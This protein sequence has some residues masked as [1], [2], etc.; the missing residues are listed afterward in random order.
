M[1][2]EVQNKTDAIE[3]RFPYFDKAELQTVADPV[4]RYRIAT[5]GVD[6]ALAEKYHLDMNRQPD[7]IASQLMAG[8][9]VRERM[10]AKQIRAAQATELSGI[11]K[12]LLS[13]ILNGA[14]PFSIIPSVL[15]PFCYNV[16]LESCHKVMFGE[17]GRIDLPVPY[18]LT[19]KAMLG[20]DEPAREFL[21]GYAQKKAEAFDR[22][23]RESMNAAET[24]IDTEADAGKNE[25]DKKQNLKP[26]QNAPRRDQLII[27]RE[28]I[29]TFLDD[30]GRRTV[31]VLGTDTPMVIRNIMR[32]LMLDTSENPTPRATFLMYLSLDTGLALDY[33]IAEDF[34]KYVPCFYT[35]ENGVRTELKDRR[36]L[37]Y[38]GICA[39]LPP[40]S[41]EQLMGKAI[42]AELASR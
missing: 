28:R 2:S 13:K 33:F 26:I 35:D 22:Q 37:R 11:N 12:T 16:L 36:V 14:R 41:R 8:M 40:E 21:L 20:L 10:K 27:I 34:T 19:A 38:I 5:I 31:Q 6:E 4:D 18:S 1:T 24:D 25:Q 23:Y 17:E 32:R 15:T 29:Q 39:T 42:G 30:T 3:L 7:L 9:Y